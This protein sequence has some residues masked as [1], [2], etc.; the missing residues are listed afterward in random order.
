MRFSLNLVIHPFS[1]SHHPSAANL[2]RP[3]RCIYS[4]VMC[5]C[6]CVNIYALALKPPLYDQ[7]LREV[8]QVCGERIGHLTALGGCG[9]SGVAFVRSHFASAA[10]HSGQSCGAVGD[11]YTAFRALA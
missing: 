4:G 6:V 9:H 10:G 5:V 7:V 11:I 8:R 3:F 2:V 1:F